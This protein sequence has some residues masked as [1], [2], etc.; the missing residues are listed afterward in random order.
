MAQVLTA[1]MSRTE[2]MDVERLMFESAVDIARTA[3]GADDPGIKATG[4][5]MLEDAER[6]LAE[7][8][9]DPDGLAVEVGFVSA[10][11]RNHLRAMA[12]DYLKLQPKEQLERAELIALEWVMH[13]VK[14]L[15]GFGIWKTKEVTLGGR[16]HIV[17]DDLML[18][19]LAAYDLIHPIRLAVV[20]YNTLELKKKASSS[21]TSSPER[22]TLIVVGANATPT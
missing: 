2:W 16:V 5:A 4:Q 9:D 7:H 13:G 11:V 12:L 18:D 17:L 1:D 22:E 14:G 19:L 8:Q 10:Q 3:S 20:R 15:R 21:P 6:K